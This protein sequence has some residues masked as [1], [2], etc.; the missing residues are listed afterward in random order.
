MNPHLPNSWKCLL[1]AG[2]LLF[3]GCSSVRPVVDRTRFY[4]LTSLPSQ[5]DS[6]TPAGKSL[7]IGVG[8]VEVPDYLLPKQIALRRGN[9][10]IHYSETLQWAERLDKGI[11]RV[12]GANLASLPGSANQVLT[13][14]RR[15]DVS[16]EVY[17]SVQRCETGEGGE[18]VLETRWRVAS[19]GAE[20]TWRTGLAQITKKGP[21]L[22]SNPDGAVATLSEALADLSRQIAAALPIP[23]TESSR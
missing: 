4:V 23:K 12:L 22:A 14:W 9:G 1:L 11:Q 10:E 7:A 8:R 2:S 20:T 16:A 21:A 3:F 6:I 17:V 13:T 19:P 18:V 5:P 15:Q